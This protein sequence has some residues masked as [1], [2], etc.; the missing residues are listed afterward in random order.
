MRGANGMRILKAAALAG[1]LAGALAAPWALPAAGQDS[2][3]AAIAYVG[4][5]ADLPLMPG[6]SEV[7]GAGV[8][9]DKASGRIVESY[10][11]GFVDRGAVLAFYRRSLPPLGWEA[12]GEASYRREGESLSFDF[13]SDADPLVLRFSLRP[14]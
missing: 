1:I 14:E 12:T 4:G 3:A 9:F 13:V 2:G 6:L 10:A 11:Q 7:E 5:V 8:V